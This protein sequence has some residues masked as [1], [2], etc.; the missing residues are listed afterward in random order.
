RTGR[1]ANSPN[2]C[3]S[4]SPRTWPAWA[5]DA[6]TPIAARRRCRAALP[7]LSS[8]RLPGPFPVCEELLEA[9]IG[10][11]MPDQCLE[12]RRRYGGDVGADQRRLLYMVYRTDRRRQDLGLE[13]VIVVDGADLRDQPHAVG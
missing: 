5:A 8:D 10:Q 9:R 1:R 6:G 11:R 3:G 7:A 2:C 12:R 13:G 4:P